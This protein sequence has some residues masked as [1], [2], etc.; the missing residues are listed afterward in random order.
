MIQKGCL[1]FVNLDT[2]SRRSYYDSKGR[3]LIKK[4]SFGHCPK[5]GGGGGGAGGSFWDLFFTMY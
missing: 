4:N 3:H 5:E 2:K 1:R